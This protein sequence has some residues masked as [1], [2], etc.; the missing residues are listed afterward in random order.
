MTFTSNNFIFKIFARF[1]L[2]KIGQNSTF[3]ENF[4]FIIRQIFIIFS[5]YHGEKFLLAKFWRKIQFFSPLF[6]LF[7]SITISRVGALYPIRFLPRVGALLLTV[8]TGQSPFDL[9]EKSLP[10]FTRD[11]NRV[12][13]RE[14]KK[15]ENGH[16]GAD[17]WFLRVPGGAR[18]HARREATNDHSD[19]KLQRYNNWKG[20]FDFWI[21]VF[22]LLYVIKHFFIHLNIIDNTSLDACCNQFFFQF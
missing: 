20:K 11:R 19:N 17:T 9:G 6:L 14:K 5:L 7:Q 22:L 13:W 8:A 18:G 4:A 15:A 21:P 1:Q 16:G 12:F 10:F 3:E 2:E